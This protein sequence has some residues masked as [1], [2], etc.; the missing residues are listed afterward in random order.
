MI[1]IIQFLPLPK[2][3]SGA[4]IAATL[5]TRTTNLSSFL[6]LLVEEEEEEEEE[7][8]EEKEVSKNT[9]LSRTYFLPPFPFG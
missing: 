4:A 1:V 6:L 5:P 8:K 3:L 9:P 7:E 2:V